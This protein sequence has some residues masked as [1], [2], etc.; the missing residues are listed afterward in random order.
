MKVY[1]YRDYEHYVE[2]QTLANVN[3]LNW[4]W[5][6]RDMTSTF[7]KHYRKFRKDPATILCHGSRNGME[8]RWFGEEFPEALVL[9]TDISH[10]A[11][12]FPN[13]VQWDMQKENPD[14]IG[15]WDMVYTNSLDHVTDFHGTLQTIYDQLTILGLFILDYTIWRDNSI[16]PS[17]SDALDVSY[18]ELKRGLRVADFE[19][20]QENQYYKNRYQQNDEKIDSYYFICQK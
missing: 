4:V 17:I 3:K 15:K 14:W 5:A 19:V 20:I 7:A 8:V 16:K 2:Q 1:R 12:D 11:T 6:T 9:G 13:Q 18:K 10:T